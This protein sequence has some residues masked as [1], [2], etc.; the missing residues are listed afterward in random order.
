MGPPLKIGLSNLAATF[1]RRRYQTL[2]FQNEGVSQPLL[3]KV[4]SNNF[5]CGYL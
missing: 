1:E 3:S 5:K 2:K 4:P